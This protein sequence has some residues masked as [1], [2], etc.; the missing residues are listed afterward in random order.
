MKGR[1]TPTMIRPQTIMA[2]TTAIAS[3]AAAIMQY[4]P[5]V[6]A[7]LGLFWYVMQIVINWPN[8]RGRFKQQGK[9]RN[10]KTNSRRT[11]QQ[12]R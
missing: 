11:K 1:L 10:A 5:P 8:F 6:V 9:R 12:S 7:I 4:V 2:E 3:V